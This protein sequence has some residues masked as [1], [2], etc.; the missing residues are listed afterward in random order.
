MAI[1]TVV[2]TASNGMQILGD[3]TISLDQIDD[4]TFPILDIVGVTNSEFTDISYI[5]GVDF[6]VNRT[7]K[8]EE[9][10]TKDPIY[11]TFNTNLQGVT[12]AISYRY[13]TTVGQVQATM[14]SDEYRAVATSNLA[15][16]CPLNIVSIIGL[17]YEGPM[18]ES[19]LDEVLLTYI[20]KGITDNKLDKSDIIAQCTNAGATFVNTSFI[21]EVKSYDFTGA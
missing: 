11:L 14:D 5:E 18:S 9:F 20:N 16:N 4:F 7:T 10:S 12:A 3:L 1:G 17:T 8:G 2:G 13:S 19:E 21:M 6:T 15:K